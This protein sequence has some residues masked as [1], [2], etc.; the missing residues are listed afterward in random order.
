MVGAVSF[1]AVL[2]ASLGVGS[3]AN[4]AMLYA[5]RHELIALRRLELELHMCNLDSCIPQIQEA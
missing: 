4:L 2:A 3:T 5:V 1:T